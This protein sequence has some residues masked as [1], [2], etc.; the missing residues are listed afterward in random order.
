MLVF[1][2]TDMIDI[3][4]FKSGGRSKVRCVRIVSAWSCLSSC[5]SR[6]WRWTY[7]HWVIPPWPIAQPPDIYYLNRKRCSS[8]SYDSTFL[9]RGAVLT[10]TSMWAIDVNWAVAGHTSVNF[11][12]WPTFWLVF[13]LVAGPGECWY[14]DYELK[15]VVLRPFPC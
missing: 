14:G 10:T 12:P 15:I 13:G 8:T 2:A 11:C 9:P 6:N 5:W 1:N 3:N 7:S 4:I